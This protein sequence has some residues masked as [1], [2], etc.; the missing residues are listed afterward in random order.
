MPDI[1]ELKFVRTYDFEYVPKYLLDQID[2]CDSDMTERIYKF[3]RMF[4]SSPLTLLYVMIDKVNVV[5]GVLWAEI[6]IIDALI[7]I[8]LL[9][10]AKEYQS[11]CGHTLEKVKEFLF[12]LDT[13]PELKKEIRFLT[14][15]PKAYEKTG[16]V[17]SSRILMELTNGNNS[18]NNTERD[19]TPDTIKSTE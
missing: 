1:E 4:A 5:K 10:V 6:N 14:T 16:A 13:G 3:G 9:S 7:F 15:R 17:N 18:K 8:R 19:R 12:G 2:D 11:S